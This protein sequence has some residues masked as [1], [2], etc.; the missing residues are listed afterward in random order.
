LDRVINSKIYNIINIESAITQILN[1]YPL[2]LVIT[3]I[4]YNDNNLD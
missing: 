3:Q 2:F 4:I 1:S